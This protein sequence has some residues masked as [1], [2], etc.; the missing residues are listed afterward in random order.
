MSPP[1]VA[2]GRRLL[3]VQLGNLTL[4]PMH[5][6]QR[7]IPA[8]LQLAGHQTIGGIDSIILPASMRRREVRLLKRQIE[9]PLWGR[10]LARL[11][12]ERFHRGIDAERLQHPQHFRADGNI[13]TEAAE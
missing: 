2:Q 5:D 3:P 13:G 10:N 4:E 11:S 1:S 8:A 9:L 6:L 7:L 12:R